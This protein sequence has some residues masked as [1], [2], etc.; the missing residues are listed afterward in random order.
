MI[1]EGIGIA[2]LGAIAYK[3]NFG[4]QEKY[5]GLINNLSEINNCFKNSKGQGVKFI[6][7]YKDKILM[8]QVKLKNK[9]GF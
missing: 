8:L 1:L 3:F 4:E 6:K 9:K 7:Y 2:T 5:K